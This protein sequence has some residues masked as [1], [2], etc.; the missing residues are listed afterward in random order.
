[1][2]LEMTPSTVV[3]ER[4]P[5]MVRPEMT[6]LLVELVMILSSVAKE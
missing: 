4:T 3:Q 5:F 2:L 1:V 6:V